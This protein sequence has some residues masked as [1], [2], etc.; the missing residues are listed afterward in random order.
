MET[1]HLYEH[2]SD[3]ECDE[4]VQRQTQTCFHVKAAH[5]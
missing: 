3:N 5:M 1:F 4:S 2:S